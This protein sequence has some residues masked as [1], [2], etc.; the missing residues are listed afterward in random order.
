PAQRAASELDQALGDAN[1]RPG[2]SPARRLDKPL[3][4]RL[5]QVDGEMFRSEELGDPGDRCLQRVRK[6]ELCDRLADDGDKRPAALELHR[7]AARMLAR[8]QRVS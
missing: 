5:E 6:R 8:A 3:L 1:M 4:F 7:L 2:E